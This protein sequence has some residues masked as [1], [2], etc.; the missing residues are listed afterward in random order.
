VISLCEIKF[1]TDP[2]SITK[3]YRAELEKKLSAFRT[4][5]K[6]RKSVFLTMV[7][8]FGM[9]ENG[10]SLGFA[11]NVITMNDLFG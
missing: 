5:T 6:T 7:T 4:V 8:T 9:E 3:S 11:Q 10:H 2:Y 1:S